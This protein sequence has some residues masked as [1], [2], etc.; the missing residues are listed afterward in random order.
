MSLTNYFQFRTDSVETEI[1]KRPNNKKDSSRK[2]EKSMSKL[3][4]N[5]FRGQFCKSLL[6]WVGFSHNWKW[7]SL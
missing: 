7:L 1:N 4:R 2:E 5:C 3:A 6:D